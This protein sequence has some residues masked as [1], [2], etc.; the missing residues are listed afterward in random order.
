M[1]PRDG[2]DNDPVLASIAVPVVLFVAVLGLSVFLHRRGDRT[3][4]QRPTLAELRSRSAY[5]P[6]P[7]TGVA[8]LERNTFVFVAANGLERRL[9]HEIQDAER[10]LIGSALQQPR[11]RRLTSDNGRPSRFKTVRVEI[12]DATGTRAGR[13]RAA[14]SRPLVSRE[15]A[16]RQYAPWNRCAP[17]SQAI[18]A[19]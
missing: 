1:Q 5:E 16:R 17:R 11:P 10:T 18:R 6:L 14:R 15:R 8:F 13:T 19:P 9:D 4:E 7:E 3:W 2:S 12:R